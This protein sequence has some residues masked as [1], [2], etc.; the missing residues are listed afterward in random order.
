MVVGILLLLLMLQWALITSEAHKWANSWK[1]DSWVYHFWGS[2][3]IWEKKG[4]TILKMEDMEV[5]CGLLRLW[6]GLCSY[7]HREVLTGCTQLIQ[8]SVCR[9]GIGWVYEGTCHHTFNKRLNFK[10]YYRQR[11]EETPASFP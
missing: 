10:N 11:K 1:S 2:W 7:E 6:H 9:V 8:E 5:C 4:G 3:Y